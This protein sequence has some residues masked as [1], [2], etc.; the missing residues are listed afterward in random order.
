MTITDDSLSWS[1]GDALQLAGPRAA[2]GIQF[3]SP[4]RT[5]P[6]GYASTAY[7]VKGDGPG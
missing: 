5:E 1:E 2:I 3:F 4:M 7:W 6:L